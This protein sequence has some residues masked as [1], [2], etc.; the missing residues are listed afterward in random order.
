MK[1]SQLH[2]LLLEPHDRTEE[3]LTAESGEARVE[4]SDLYTLGNLEGLNYRAVFHMS[5]SL[6]R[7][8]LEGVQMLY[9]GQGLQT[10]K[11]KLFKIL[12]KR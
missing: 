3:L 9:L 6:V 12:I 10:P 1:T 2:A 4:E 7:S 5:G 8:D 11:Q